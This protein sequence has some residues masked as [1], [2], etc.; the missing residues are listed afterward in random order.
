MKPATFVLAAA[1]ASSFNIFAADTPHHG[2]HTPQATTETEEQPYAGQES[3]AV[4]SLSNDETKALLSGAGMGLAKP[5][6]LNHYPGPKHAIDLAAELEMTSEQVAAARNAFD[7]MKRD[8][9]RLGSE[10]V[11]K[12]ASLDQLFASGKATDAEVA[13]ATSEIAA[14]QGRLRATHLRA[15]L[16]MHEIMTPEQIAA[17]DAKRGY[18]R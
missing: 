8:A 15:H 12:E 2:N 6:E 9:T 14:L 16:R 7:A 11:A 3:R 10:I 5:A 4:K 13:A 1:L 18:A 17:Y